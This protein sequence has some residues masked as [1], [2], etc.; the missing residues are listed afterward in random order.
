MDQPAGV[1]TVGM[2]RDAAH[3]VHRDR[4]AGH[5]DVAFARPIRPRLIERNGL[6][7]SGLGKFT[8]NAANC[9]GGNT[10]FD[11]GP[12]RRIV[13]T[14]IAFRH[15]NER[16][17]G[18][19]PVW[20]PVLTR[21]RRLRRPAHGADESARLAISAQRMPGRVAREKSVFGRTGRADHQPAGVGVAGEIVEIDALGT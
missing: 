10:G 6:V 14:K 5:F 16:W 20:Q 1:K 3:G 2:G 15:Q 21:E 13:R 8:S 18:C 7:E 12:F 9:F 19:A 17:H 11:C 4:A